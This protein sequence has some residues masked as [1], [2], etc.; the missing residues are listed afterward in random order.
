MS[1]EPIEPFTEAEIVRYARGVVTQ[2]Y[3]VANVEDHDWQFSLMLLLS[4]WD[5]DEIPPNLSTVFLVPLA[6]HM[7]GRWLNGRVPG[8]TISAVCVAMESIDALNAK[9][10]EMWAVLNPDVV[11]P[12]DTK[13]E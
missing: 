1:A 7:G 3:M 8:V 6:A 10:A 12:P 2:E 4:A 13:V 9:I 11:T 5:P